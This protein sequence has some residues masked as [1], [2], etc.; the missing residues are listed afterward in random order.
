MSQGREGG[1]QV[2]VSLHIIVS[3]RIS[4]YVWTCSKALGMPVAR[5]VFGMRWTSCG[6]KQEKSMKY[7]EWYVLIM[8]LISLEYGFLGFFIW[9]SFLIGFELFYR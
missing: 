1:G 8:F 9:M 6:P 4:R 7:F 2:G 3:L 5:S